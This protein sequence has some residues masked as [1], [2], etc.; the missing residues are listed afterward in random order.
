M[1][2]GR[3]DEATAVSVSRERCEAERAEMPRTTTATITIPTIR[4]PI[5]I[6]R[7]IPC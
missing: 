5:H 7:L 2:T 4:I 1:M 3:R 6:P